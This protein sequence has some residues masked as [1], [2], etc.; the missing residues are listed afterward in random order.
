M[1]WVALWVAIRAE[2]AAFRDLEPPDHSLTE[3]T[4]GQFEYRVYNSLNR[5]AAFHRAIETLKAGNCWPFLCLKWGPLFQGHGGK[6]SIYV[7]SS[8]LAQINKAWSQAI[9][10]TG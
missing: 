4:E 8:G 7:Y 10:R 2:S 5:G 6:H 1:R 3:L 9:A